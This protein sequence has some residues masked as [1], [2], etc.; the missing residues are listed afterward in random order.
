MNYG[1]PPVGTMDDEAKKRDSR[2]KINPSSVPAYTPPSERA[3][4]GA[5]SNEMSLEKAQLYV[6]QYFPN[7]VQGADRGQLEGL[8]RLKDD[9]ARLERGEPMSRQQVER[10]D[11]AERDRMAFYQGQLDALKMSGDAPQK[12]DIFEVDT[13]QPSEQR[14][15]EAGQA[16]VFHAQYQA[17]NPDFNFTT[18]AKAE[19]IQLPSDSLSKTGDRASVVS[20]T[21]EGKALT[22]SYRME[23]DRVV[24]T[25]S[26][27]Y[28]KAMTLAES[29]VVQADRAEAINRNTAN[30]LEGMKANPSVKFKQGDHTF[31]V[32]GN[33]LVRT[34]AQGNR[35]VMPL[36]KFEENLKARQ[37]Q[38]TA[39]QK[40]TRAD[41]K[42]DNKM[43]AEIKDTLEKRQAHGQK[44]EH[45]TYDK[46]RTPT[47]W[48]LDQKGELH[49]EKG[50]RKEQSVDLNS[51]TAKLNERITAA[52]DAQAFSGQKT[53]VGRLREKEA[54]QGKGATL[55]NPN[56]GDT[57]RL[58]EDGKKL[59]CTDKN[60]K[61]SEPVDAQKSH[62]QQER[63]NAAKAAEQEKERTK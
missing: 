23:G 55:K 36:A 16:T 57:F 51:A 35:G 3:K 62:E 41:L 33:N 53:V 7:T 1:T 52:K 46:E 48:T 8:D 37:D 18:V 2:F 17:R 56:N 28:E 45:V 9:V 39:L 15:W 40:T 61:Q 22:N 47:K 50:Q 31:S 44:A 29:R 43:R 13:D 12:G 34:D 60:G 24:H 20:Y 38:L 54:E 19:P 63:L 49:G 10:I 5:K 6:N 58:S 21:A 25:N 30:A 4:G 26:Q 32:E 42:A 59:H 11:Q 27:G 14:A